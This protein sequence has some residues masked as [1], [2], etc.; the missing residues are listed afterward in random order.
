MVGNKCTVE[1]GALEEV[2]IQI[3]NDFS[4]RQQVLS[5]LRILLGSI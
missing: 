4:V 3:V 2:F 5:R 1:Y